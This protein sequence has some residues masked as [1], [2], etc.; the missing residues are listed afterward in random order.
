MAN[1]KN[2]QMGKTVC[3]DERIA[4]SKSM[5]GLRTA[6]TYLPTNSVVDVKTLEYS[7][8]DGDKLK[9][10]LE[11]GTDR[12]VKATADYRP[13]PTVNGN[14]MAEVCLSRDHAFAAVQLLRYIQMNYEP[15]T[16]VLFFDGDAARVVCQLFQ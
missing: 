4:V 13:Q 14:Y 3:A 10:L 11:S 5:L 7:A 12:I 1:I 16:D 8:A 15:V 2:M 6:V 9:A